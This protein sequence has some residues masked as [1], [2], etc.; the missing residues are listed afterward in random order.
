[1]DKTSDQLTSLLTLAV[2]A[3]TMA[4]E[5]IFTNRPKD[6][7]TKAHA[8]DLVTEQDSYVEKML[9]EVLE[10]TLIPILGEELGGNRDFTS[11]WVL[12][13]IDGTNNF[14]IGSP[15][16]GVNIALFENNEVILAVTYLPFLKEIYT[17]V[18]GQGVYFN[19]NKLPLLPIEPPSY[20]P[21]IVTDD[22]PLA[23]LGYPKRLLG[24]A[25][26]ELAW[27][28]KGSFSAVT[29]QN[30]EPWDVAPGVLFIEEVG[31]LVIP[32]ELGKDIYQNGVILGNRNVVVE[33]GKNLV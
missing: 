31:G 9:R 17:S 6:I 4:G 14:V 8:F 28:A 13:P 2:K 23:K 11:L 10:P 30:V 12:D 3:A 32:R 7:S 25:S 15:L 24:A 5:Y 21:I 16:V 29:Y 19:G 20:L 1:M 26:V 27:C 22:D 18:R 33:L